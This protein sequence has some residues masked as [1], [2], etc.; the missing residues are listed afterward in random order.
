MYKI[1]NYAEAIAQNKLWNKEL[2]TS[3][4]AEWAMDSPLA[5]EQHWANANMIPYIKGHDRGWNNNVKTQIQKVVITQIQK[6]MKTQIQKVV[7][8]QI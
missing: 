4:T 7:E 6:V 2:V 1:D 8:T 5:T 3:S